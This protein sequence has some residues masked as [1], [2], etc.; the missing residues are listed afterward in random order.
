MKKIISNTTRKSGKRII[1]KRLLNIVYRILF[2]CGIR[3]SFT[4]NNLTLHN[5]HKYAQEQ[6]PLLL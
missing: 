3:I 5:H 4:D 6:N 1:T 2:L